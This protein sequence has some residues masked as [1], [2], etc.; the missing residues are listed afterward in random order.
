MPGRN[1]WVKLTYDGKPERHLSESLQLTFTEKTD[2]IISFKEACA[3]SAQ[4]I[5]DT[6]KNV[7]ISLSGGCDSECVANS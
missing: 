1:N 3:E 2:R 5:S 4:E 6:F 7:Y